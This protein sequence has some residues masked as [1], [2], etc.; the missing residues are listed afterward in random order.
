MDNGYLCIVDL[1]EDDGS[2]HKLEKD[3]KGHN[4]FNQNELKKLLEQLGYNNVVT[5]VFYNDV[6]VIEDS[7]INY[8]LFCMIGKKHYINS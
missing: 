2:F 3:F 8:S 5:N 1:V 6:K 4:G 7:E